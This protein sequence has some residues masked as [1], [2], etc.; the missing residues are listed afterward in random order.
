MDLGAWMKDHKHMLVGAA[1]LDG[2]G[3]SDAPDAWVRWVQ[4]D[5]EAVAFVDA[6]QAGVT[7]VTIAAPANTTGFIPVPGL[8]AT[9]LASGAVNV[10]MPATRT[11]PVAVR[12][13]TSGK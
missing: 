10:K 13:R 4:R 7:S 5:G 11:G 2:L 6:L 8:E 12:F 3:A 1:P 9:V